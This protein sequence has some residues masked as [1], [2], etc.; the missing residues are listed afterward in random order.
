LTKFQI[1]LNILI[2]SKVCLLILLCLFISACSTAEKQPAPIT[3]LRNEIALKQGYHTVVRGETLYFIAW[4]YSKD[5]QE[6]AAINHLKSP[7]ALTVGQKLY[8]SS[9]GKTVIIPVEP[10][11][12][13]MNIAVKTWLRPAKGN[14]IGTY[15]ILNKGVNIAGKLN[16]SV[17]ATA[18]GQVVYAGDG[19][20]GYGNLLILKHNNEYLSAYAHN[21]TLLVKEGEW[22]KAGQTIATMGNTGTNQVMLHFEIR[23]RGQPINPLKLIE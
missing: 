22:V 9:N 6:L 13:A 5:Y 17:V 12:S 3:D 8:L 23:K 4:R 11:N 1:G 10:S 7:Y 15:S 16:E 21:Q 2:R 19:L 20:R 14:V 18:S